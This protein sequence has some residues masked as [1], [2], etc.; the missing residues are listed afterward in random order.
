M[1]KEN[2]T[3]NYEAPR[4]EVIEVEIEKGFATSGGN[5]EGFEPW[6]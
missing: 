6:Q 4:V 5:T 3:L 1:Q 2:V